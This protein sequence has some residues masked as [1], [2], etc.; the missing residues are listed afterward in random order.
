MRILSIDPATKS[1]AVS[2]MD[3]N[4]NWLGDIVQIGTDHRTRFHAE[5]D[6]D[7]KIRILTSWV[8]QTQRVLDTMF[9]LHYVNVFDL[10]PNM[11]VNN[12]SIEDRVMRLKGVVE[13][14]KAINSKLMPAAPISKVLIEYQM[15]ANDKSRSIS[16]ALAYAFSPADYGFSFYGTHLDKS[17]GPAMGPADSAPPTT[18]ELVG[19]ALKGKIYFGSA[20]HLHDF[21]KK[22]MGNYA[23]NKAHAKYNFLKWLDD[24]S[25]RDLIAGIPKA[26]LDDVADSFLMGY[27]WAVKTSLSANKK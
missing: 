17:G 24:N 13:Y 16:T 11:K 22:Y 2:I 10:L 19:P 1:L 8:E 3:F 26:N 7:V 5:G 25:T 23:G 9:S 20:G 4:E 6:P 18:V 12:I 15:S 21:R 27:A 14:I